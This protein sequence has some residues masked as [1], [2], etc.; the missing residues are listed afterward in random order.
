[1]KR[2][3]L[4]IMISAA[5]FAS[6]MGTT[7]TGIVH[8]ADSISI[9][10]AEQI[11]ELKKEDGQVRFEYEDPSVLQPK[12]SLSKRSASA[13]SLPRFSLVDT[14]KVTAVRNQGS[15]DN[16]WTYGALASM[17][18]SLLMA[19]KADKNT[20]D[21]SE[22]HL[23]WFTYKGSNS[24]TKSAYAGKD[25]FV[26]YNSGNPY[27]EGGNYYLSSATLARWYG[28]VDQSRASSVSSLSSGIQTI[29]DIRLKNADFLPDPKTSAGRSVIKQY[30]TAKG[31]VDASYYHNNSYVR[32]IDGKTTYYC[33]AGTNYANHEVAI[34]GWDDTVRTE[35]GT[36]AWI[37]RNSYGADW[38]NNGGY[39]YLSYND[40]SLCDAAFFEAENQSYQKAS[41]KHDYTSIYQYDGVG[42]GDSL[43]VSSK[44]ISAANRFTA[45]KDEVI[46]AVGVFTGAANSTVS[47]SVYL[48]PSSN[49]PASGV[50]KYSKTF[51]VPYA[52]HHTLALGQSIGVPKG[53]TF[54]VVLSVSHT[55][56][57]SRQYI[58]P[59]ETENIRGA[60]IASIDYSK[61]QSYLNM[62]N[63]WYDVTKVAP[64][65]STYDVGNA[66][67]KAFAASAGT[68]SQSISAKGSF[69]KTYGNKAFSLKAKRT[70]G[71]GALSYKSSNT[72]VATVSSAGKVSLKGPGRATITITAAPTASYKSAVK[73]VTV[74][75]K[76][77]R[78]AI[79]S[80]KS[81][82][83]KTLTVR[84]KRA[85]KATGYQVSVARNKSFKKGRKT[86]T[87]TR[88]A[89][90]K[91]TFKKLA[92][93]KTYYVKVRSYKKS[94][95]KKIYGSYS[96]I[97]KVRTK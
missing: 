44:K 37:V 79:R 71:N 83:S 85:T 41:T 56:N 90:T 20:L 67:V 43:F 16:C 60:E 49:N 91:K 9:P 38:G 6:V 30:L 82:K 57:G 10:D 59:L 35:G 33:S 53:H 3:I 28:A 17:E 7:N 55:Q 78:A 45:R 14:G 76:P 21:L 88:Q 70:R 1:M 51:S 15:S 96:K 61:G 46:Q 42:A 77:K 69:T 73:K 23:T 48:N 97:K 12:T 5:M 31:A 58:I 94:G 63:K 13:A 66:V 74:T 62:S 89:T 93:R 40:K 11:G 29:S 87:I 8:A 32:N 4:S 27:G 2:R 26:A 72:S 24:S 84:W 25:T 92:S 54:S 95:G 52:G 34:V 22:N 47:V 50:K 68:A 36:G 81:T 64:I 18:S 19:G 75:V 86:A 80:A 39:F 65:R